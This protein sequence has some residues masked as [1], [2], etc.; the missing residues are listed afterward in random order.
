MGSLNEAMRDFNIQRDDLRFNIGRLEA[1]SVKVGLQRLH[2]G[3]GDPASR[4]EAG[5]SCR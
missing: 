5:S 2:A 3:R 4:G 1:V